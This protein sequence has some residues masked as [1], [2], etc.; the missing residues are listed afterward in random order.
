ML[1]IFKH[2]N[3]QGGTSWWHGHLARALP[4]SLCPGYIVFVFLAFVGFTS[5]ATAQCL[6]DEL[7][8]L[9]A[10]DATSGDHYGTSVIILGDIAI[11]GA[12]KANGVV[13]ATGAAYVLSYD[14]IMEMW[15]DQ[16]KVVAEDGNTF[17]QFAQ[18]IAINPID[19]NVIIIGAWADDDADDCCNCSSC[20]SG[21]A[22][23][24]R[25]DTDLG[26]WVQ[27]QK[28]TASDAHSQDRF[29]W[30]VSIWGDVAIIGARFHDHPSQNSGTA[31]V[32]RYDADSGTWNEQQEILS[33]DPGTFGTSISLEGDVV[34]IGAS[35][36]Q[37]FGL[38]S[39]A[40]YIFRM[41][42][43]TQIWQLEQKLLPNDPVIG[44]SFGWF[45]SL[46]GNTALIAA[47]GA[48]GIE[49]LEGA[50]YVFTYDGKQWT[51]QH[52]L[53]AS[54][55]EP[56]DTF[57]RTVSLAGNIAV[58]A[59]VLDDVDGQT[60]GSTYIYTFD[61]QQWNE[62][63]K[64]YA[65]EFEGAEA[66]GTHAA[67][68]GV[69]VIVGANFAII[70][71]HSEAGAAFIFGGLGDCNNNGIIDIC[72]IADGNAADKNNNGLPDE[73]DKPPCPWDIDNS[74][75]VG[76]GDLL[77]M[78][79]QWGTAGPADFNADGIVNTSDLLILLAN[80]GACP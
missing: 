47:P 26:L 22:Y 14:S 16:Q 58:V 62:T 72:D 75:S 35:Q 78:F 51:Q 41:D 76:V 1:S 54:D 57:G 37:D 66:F 80:W 12:N 65:S 55:G 5:P 13:G 25:F 67:T 43:D 46:D 32:F 63:A 28:L 52:K 7:Q 19:P 34:L 49:F 56:L 45:V 77:M 29:G 50:A 61:S 64:L 44:A 38:G 59:A 21:S 74:G 30:S 31:Y 8:K 40:A 11:S 10:S 39:G 60:V 73:C 6:P 53:F 48:D 9:T 71:G 2:I 79:A 33:P 3:Q 68:D 42:P 69:N 15:V 24:F 20:Q 17:D 36:D 23:I 70:D 27:E 18:S 4:F